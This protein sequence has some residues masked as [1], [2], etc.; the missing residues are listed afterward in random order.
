MGKDNNS[1]EVLGEFC[2]KE[3]VLQL[4]KNRSIKGIS[5]DKE[6]ID[7]QSS[8]VSLDSY[9]DSITN[10]GEVFHYDYEFD[11]GPKFSNL[12]N[13]KNIRK[14]KKRKNYQWNRKKIRF[15]VKVKDPSPPKFTVED[16][17]F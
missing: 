8:L 2:N 16:M 14:K 4:S 1:K 12:D 17:H 13:V 3:N 5:K 11:E 6:L 10:K 9:V 7:D 15:K